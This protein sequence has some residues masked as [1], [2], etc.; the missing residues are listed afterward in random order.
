MSGTGSTGLDVVRYGG[1]IAVGGRRKAQ[2]LRSC[3]WQG[4]SC[5]HQISMWSSLVSH[6]AV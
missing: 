3:T 2:R 5:E 4:L 6:T 1:C